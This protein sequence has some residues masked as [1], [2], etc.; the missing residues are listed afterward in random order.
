MRD[1]RAWLTGDGDRR[2]TGG[3]ARSPAPLSRVR[4]PADRVRT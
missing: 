4:T 3:T 1:D 2:R